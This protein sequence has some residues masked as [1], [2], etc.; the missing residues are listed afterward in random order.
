[1][2]DLE[3]IKH[4]KYCMDNLA[5]GIDPTT[6][7]LLP[8]DT[9]LNNIQLSRCFFLASDILRQVYENGGAVGQRRKIVLPPFSLPD[10]IRDQIEIT[11]EPAM[12]RRF[13]DRINEL[14]DVGAMQKLKVT[15]MTSWLV[16]NGYLCEETV[17]DKKR[18]TPTNQGEKLG[19]S[20]EYREGQY[21]GY[22]AIMYDENAQHHLVSNLDEIIAISNGDQA[23]PIQ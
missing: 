3:K 22:L 17:N 18:K 21:G 1:M 5:E 10:E 11:T 8:E 7:E 4:A 14:V 6:G 16:K 15:A 2:T 12:I 13:T 9:L 23:D 19:I 20:A